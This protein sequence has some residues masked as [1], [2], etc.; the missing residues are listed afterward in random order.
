MPINDIIF[1]E[2]DIPQDLAGSSSIVNINT[3]QPECN[4]M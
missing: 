2:Y 1:R 4:N 3:P